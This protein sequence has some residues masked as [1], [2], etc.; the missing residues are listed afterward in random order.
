LTNIVESFTDAY[1]IMTRTP[2][3]A[4]ALTAAVV[5][6]T[7]FDTVNKSTPEVTPSAASDTV[8][9]NVTADFQ[10][11]FTTSV[12][13]PNNATTRFVIRVNGVETIWVAQA[14]NVGVGNTSEVSMSGLITANAGSSLDIG[15]SSL[16]GNQTANF[17]N[18]S[19]IVNDVQQ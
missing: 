3:T 16:T 14:T 17:I 8:G 9:L 5:P 15:V 1:G 13:G 2:T 19:L 18:T 4:L 10:F 11:D 7:V 12:S 6:F